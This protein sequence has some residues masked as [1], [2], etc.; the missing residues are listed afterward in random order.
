MWKEK[1]RRQDREK[2]AE[3]CRCDLYCRTSQFAKPDVTRNCDFS[4]ALLGCN[5]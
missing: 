1:L 2:G 5:V 4:V 3:N